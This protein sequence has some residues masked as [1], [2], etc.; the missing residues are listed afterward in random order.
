MKHV[1]FSLVEPKQ[2][3]VPAPSCDGVNSGGIHLQR[4]F[5]L[6]ELSIVLVILGLLTGGILAGQSLIRA[7]ELRAVVKEQEQYATAHRAF[8][9]KYFY[10][11]GDLPNA[12]AFWG[13]AGGN[14]SNTACFQVKSTDKRT[15]NGNGNGAIDTSNWEDARYWAQLA[16]AGL[17][18][19]FYDGTW[20]PPSYAVRINANLPGSKISSAAWWYIYTEPTDNLTYLALATST[21]DGILAP[22]EAWNIDKKLDD[23]NPNNGRVFG[24]DTVTGLCI[25]GSNPNEYALSTKAKTCVMSFLP[26]N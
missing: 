25:N 11:A 26:Y 9:D 17:I 13:S 21:N 20:L 23:G 15:C 22:E 4:A 1:A 2:S 8:Q 16:N 18:S 3:G 10:M 12:T 14:G 24:T 7:A 19:G 6:V 5:S